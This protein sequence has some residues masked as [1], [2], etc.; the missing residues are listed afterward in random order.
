MKDIILAGRS[1]KTINWY[2]NN[3]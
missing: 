1:E 3:N 2:L